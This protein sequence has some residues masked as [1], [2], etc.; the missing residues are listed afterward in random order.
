MVKPNDLI[1]QIA[2]L[3]GIA[4]ANRFHVEIPQIPAGTQQS[5][6]IIAMLCDSVS[7]PG[8]NI[9][10]VEDSPLRNLV[11]VATGYIHDDVEF[12]FILD[13]TYAPKRFFEEWIKLVVNPE[14]Y[15]VSYLDSVKRDITVLQ[16]DTLNNVV[17]GV[18]LIGAYPISIGAIQLSNDNDGIQKMPVTITFERVVKDT[19]VR[20]KITDAQSIETDAVQPSESDTFVAE[21]GATT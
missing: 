7:I 16:L 1:S 9:N 20:E 2:N 6:L 5:P 10:T 8:T 12:S 13:G 11:K 21:R 15:R 4:R 18:K 14:T 19:V 17:Y 3:N